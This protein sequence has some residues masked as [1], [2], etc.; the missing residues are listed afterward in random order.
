MLLSGKGGG[1]KKLSVR[2]NNYK[3]KNPP[4]SHFQMRDS[5]GFIMFFAKTINSV[6]ASLP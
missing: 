2:I 5:G 6:M 1:K 4:V 3:L